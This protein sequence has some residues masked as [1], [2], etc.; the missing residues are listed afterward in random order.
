ML[1][2][3]FLVQALLQVSLAGG[4]VTRSAGEG[5]YG[6]RRHSSFQAEL[7]TI[8]LRTQHPLLLNTREF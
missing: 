1:Q 5:D 7:P 2:T 6:Q 4:N 8:C 3:G